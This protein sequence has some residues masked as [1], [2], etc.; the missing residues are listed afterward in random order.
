MALE[1]VNEKSSDNKIVFNGK[2]YTKVFSDD[3]DGD[4]LDSTKWEKCPEWQRQDLGGYWCNDYAYL[5]DGNLV[6]EANKAG[7]KLLSGAIRS[8]GKFYQGYGLYKI[9]FKAE[10]SSGCWYAF[11][12]MSETEEIINGTATTGA[13]IDIFEILSNDKNFPE[14]KQSYLNS[15][16]HW[17][18]YGKDHK[19]TANQHFIDDSFYDKWHEVTFEW[20]PEYYKAYLDDAKEPYWNTE[21][22]A[23]KYGGIN[24]KENYVKITAEF[25]KWGGPL[26]DNLLPAHMYVDWVKVYKP[27]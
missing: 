24:T 21:G 7:D 5:K 2:N 12:L 6:L 1:T 26:I 23:E 27:E 14:G 3:F 8:K 9:R 11:W 22:E 15:A 16:V 17:D 19:S 25:G 10:K 4:T 13:E 18:G 20:T